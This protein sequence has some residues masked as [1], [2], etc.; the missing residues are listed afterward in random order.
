MALLEGKS[1]VTKAINLNPQGTTYFVPLHL[2]DSEM[3]HQK[4][5]NSN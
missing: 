1:G 5:E 3:F 2:V 4:C